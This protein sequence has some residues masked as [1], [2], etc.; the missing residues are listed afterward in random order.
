MLQSYLRSGGPCTAARNLSFVQVLRKHLGFRL[1]DD[2]NVPEEVA[3]R[4]LALR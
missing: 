3:L 4:V 2:L 1:A